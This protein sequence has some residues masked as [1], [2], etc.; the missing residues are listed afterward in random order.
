MNISLANLNKEQ[1]KS[2]IELQQLLDKIKPLSFYLYGSFAKNK[3]NCNS[4][5]DFMII[6][7]NNFQKFN[8]IK[9]IDKIFICIKNNLLNIF[10]RNIDLVVMI[11]KNKLQYYE[12]DFDPNTNFIYNVYNEGIN[13]YGKNDNDL[14]IESIKYG[15]Y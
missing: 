7:K 1:I 6:L 11:H 4:D 8:N 10:K 3:Q 2:N 14:I 5:I 13:I 12:N 15:K 9:N